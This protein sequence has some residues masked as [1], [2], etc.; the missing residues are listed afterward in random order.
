MEDCGRAVRGWWRRHKLEV[1][2]LPGT[3]RLVFEDLPTSSGP[4]GRKR[5]KLVRKSRE[6]WRRETGTEGKEVRN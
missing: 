4:E 5:R 1:S 6:K 2:L 3:W